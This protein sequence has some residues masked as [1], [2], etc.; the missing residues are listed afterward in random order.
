MTSLDKVSTGKNPLHP[1]NFIPHFQNILLYLL[2]NTL[3]A[4]IICSF[5]KALALFTLHIGRWMET[6]Q[7]CVRCPWTGEHTCNR[8]H[9]EVETEGSGVQGHPLLYTGLEAG[10]GYR[11]SCFRSKTKRNPKTL[12]KKQDPLLPFG[13]EWSIHGRWDCTR[14]IKPGMW[15][16]EDQDSTRSEPWRMLTIWQ[17]LLPPD[18]TVISTNMWSISSFLRPD[19]CLSDAHW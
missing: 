10:L 19:W 15:L 6:N 1:R 16:P 9:W 12:K 11:S 17:L 18:V 13:S 7:S 3:W 5:F 4:R 14:E 2:I 8:S